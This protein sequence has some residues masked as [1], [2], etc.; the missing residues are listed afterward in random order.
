M[1]LYYHLIG[2]I[3]LEREDFTKAIEYFKKSISLLHSQNSQMRHN[4]HALLINSLALAYY[5]DGDFKKAIEEYEKIISLTEGRRRWGDI[6]AKSFY[7]LGKIYEQKGQKDKAIEHYQKFLDLWK[8]ADP[9]IA[10]IE[11]AKKRLA[12]LKS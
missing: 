6:Y 9:G 3:E 8:N 1:R 4:D 2:M 10:E 7:M 11:D 12:G 5:K